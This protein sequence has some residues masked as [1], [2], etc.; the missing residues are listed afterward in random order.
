MMKLIASWFTFVFVMP[1]TIRRIRSST[2]SLMHLQWEVN[3]ISSRVSY[4]SESKNSL[5][6]LEV[7]SWPCSCIVSPNRLRWTRSYRSVPALCWLTLELCAWACHPSRSDSDS[8]P[9]Q[10]NH[11]TASTLPP[12]GDRL[13]KTRVWDR[14]RI[15]GR[16]LKM[17]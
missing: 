16:P 10:G 1:C 4:S 11:Y 14:C 2:Q 15:K 7:F 12:G 9:A 13:I 17:R 6:R 8:D 5:I 3:Q